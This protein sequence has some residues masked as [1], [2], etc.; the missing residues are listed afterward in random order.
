MILRT[1]VLLLGASLSIVGCGD[2]AASGQGGGGGLAQGTSSSGG[3]TTESS[4]GTSTAQ[5]D[6]QGTSSAGGSSVGGSTGAGEGGGNEGGG[7]G[8]PHV[9]LPCE[10]LAAPGVWERISPPGSDYTTS[11][12]PLDDGFPPQTDAIALR[13]DNN[14]IYVGVNEGGIHRSEDCGTTWTKVST[15]TNSEGLDDGA[16]WNLVIDPVDPD[17]MYVV[18][19]YGSGPWKSTNGG[20]DWENPVPPEVLS[21]FENG[22]VG[23]F[24]MDPTDHLHLLVFPHN[25][26]VGRFAGAGCLGETRDGGETWTVLTAPPFLEGAG[27]IMI[28]ADTWLYASVNGL[29]LTK[30][31]GNQWTQLEVEGA[32]EFNP[33][34]A[35][36]A[37]GTFF[38]ATRQGVI[39]SADAEQWTMVAPV[40]RLVPI[41][42]SETDL[43]AADQWSDWIFRIPQADPAAAVRLE[44]YGGPEGAGS[45]YL[46]YDAD[47]HL[48]YASRF[49][50]GLWRMVVE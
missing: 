32:D 35:R 38:L 2:D 29:W 11:S 47:H 42:A 39:Q 5:G 4:A 37:D 7:G 6:P 8:A 46:Q 34:M 43:F 10:G 12:E 22:F 3:A 50:G 19:G 27:P 45:P 33:T 49:S 15:G 17:V 28:D 9:V 20:V 14:A 16:P 24:A 30:D 13:S 1:P 26:C 40:G 41:V 21:V 44:P 25:P 31:A 18:N 36:G 23:G 48:L